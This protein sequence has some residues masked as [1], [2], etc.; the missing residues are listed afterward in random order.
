[1]GHALDAARAVAQAGGFGRGPF[2]R[3]G[4]RAGVAHDR[5]GHVEVD[6]AAEGRGLQVDV[7]ADEGVLAA[8]GARD[9]AAGRTASA[10]EEGLEDVAESAESAA[11]GEALPALA[12]AHIVAAALLRV[13]EHIVGQ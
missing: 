6:G 8:L 3:A 1:A 10:T 7:D 9:R 12:A 11:G 2:L 4:T 13:G 5:G